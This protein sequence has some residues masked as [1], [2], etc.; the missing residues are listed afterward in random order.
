MKYEVKKLERSAVEVKIFLDKEE[1]NPILDKTVKKV[2]DNIEIPGFRKGK[3]PKEAVINANREQIS[4]EVAGEAINSNF[5]EIIEKEKIEPVSYVRIKN[6]DLNNTLEVI[7]DIDVYPE[8]EISNYKGLEV[9]KRTFEMTD[10]RLN[11]EIETLLNTNSKLEEVI[12]NEYKAELGDT[13][14]L[15]FEGFMDGVPFE[16]G[17]AESHLLKL[18]SKSFIDNF[19]EQ[20]VGYVK[21]QEGEINVKFPEEYHSNELAGKPALFKVKINAIKKLVKPELNDDFAKTLSYESLEDLKAKKAEEITR[22]EKDIIENEYTGKLLEEIAKN[23]TIEIPV[24]MVNAEID[25]RMREMEYQLSAQGFKVDDY[26]K[27]MGANKEMFAAQITPSAEMKVKTD[28]I[29]AKIAKLENVEVSPEEISSKMEE[30]AKMYG[31]DITALEN[32]LKKYNNLENFKASL[33]TDIMMKKAIDVVISN[34]K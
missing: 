24:S 16:G 23:T 26:L 28:L 6:I 33:H 1:L 3:A 10:E 25:N 2:A 7:F 29:L 30:V 14:D 18:G 19:E 20:L 5:I 32:E 21:G 11:K 27:M 34:A 31:M 15:A 4:E 17:K 12:E 9:E 22:R 8:F 13:V